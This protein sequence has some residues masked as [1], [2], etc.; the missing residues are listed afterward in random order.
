MLAWTLLRAHA[1]PGDHDQLPSDFSIVLAQ[2]ATEQPRLEEETLAAELPELLLATE[3]LLDSLPSE[4]KPPNTQSTLPLPEPVSLPA[5]RYSSA[6]ILGLKAEIARIEAREKGD[7][8]SL[9]PEGKPARRFDGRARVRVFGVEGVGNKFVYLF[10]RSVS[11]DGPLLAAA[12]EQLIASLES[13]ESVHQFQIVF[14]NYEVQLW[15]ITRGQNRIAFATDRNKQLARQYV[16]GITAMGGTLRRE[17]LR[18]AI[19]MRSDAIFFLTDTDTPMAAGD[20]ASAIRR[21]RRNS[22]AIHTIEFGFN[23]SQ[24]KENFLTQLAQA[25]GGQYDYVDTSKLTTR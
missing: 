10:D 12:K 11:M 9:K 25:T 21:A 6:A 8:A 7:T 20:V 5:P 22:T 3:S 1:L 2:M 13:L 18:R 24:S 23:A 15:D 17:A 16:R 19:A 14:F 4:E